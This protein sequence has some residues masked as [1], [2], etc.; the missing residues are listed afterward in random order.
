V[1]VEVRVEAP[2]MRL[3]LP[4]GFNQN[5]NPVCDILFQLITPDTGM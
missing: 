2:L 1:Q 5:C 4:N 3:E